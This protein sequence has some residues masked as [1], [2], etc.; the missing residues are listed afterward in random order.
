MMY[1]VVFSADSKMSRL[2]IKTEKQKIVVGHSSIRVSK[3]YLVFVWSAEQTM[4][5]C[6]VWSE[7]LHNVCRVLLMLGALS[8]LR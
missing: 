6:A 4:L 3:H 5:D 2:H 1:S 8:R 7:S